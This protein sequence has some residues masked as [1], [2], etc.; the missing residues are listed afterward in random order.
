[1][2]VEHPNAEKPTP[3]ELAQLERLQRAIENAVADG[4]ISR[5]ELDNIRAVT[6]ADR[7]VTVAELELYR[8]LVLDKIEKGELEYDW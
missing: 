6:F 2:K 3:E 4:K 5:Q 8:K 7:K 1:M